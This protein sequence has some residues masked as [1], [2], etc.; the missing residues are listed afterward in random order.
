MGGSIAFIASQYYFQGGLVQKETWGH[1]DQWVWAKEEEGMDLDAGIVFI[2]DDTRVD[3]I[4]G[5]CYELDENKKRVVNQ[6]Y[7]DAISRL[8]ETDGFKELVQQVSETSHE[9]TRFHSTP[10]SPEQKDD[11]Q[12]QLKLYREQL[13]QKLGIT[14]WQ[15]AGTLLHQ[16]NLQTLLV[17]RKRDESVMSRYSLNK[18]IQDLLE[19]EGILYLPSQ[20]TVEAQEFWENYFNDHPDKRPSKVVYYGGDD[21]TQALRRW[22]QDQD[23]QKKSQEKQVGFTENDVY[24]GDNFQK[25]TRNMDRFR[26][27]AENVI[28]NYFSSTA[29]AAA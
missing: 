13:E 21:P 26:N 3:A 18:T 8:V 15:L 29:R 17:S 14:D 25:I 4:T 16:D 12:A 28:E 20:N 27:I 11:L 10:L 19:K 23:I 6:A 22:R 1:A 24:T 7:I 9:L 2:P 5:S